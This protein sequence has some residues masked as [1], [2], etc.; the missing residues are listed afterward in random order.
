MKKVFL[1][2]LMSLLAISALAQTDTTIVIPKGAKVWLHWIAPADTDVVAYRIYSHSLY[3]KDS[4]TITSWFQEST[5]KLKSSAVYTMPLP[6]G[7]GYFD[8]IAIDRT[9]LRSALSNKAK[10]EII[11]VAPGAPLIVQLQI[12]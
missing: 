4:L 3:G 9:N 6:V 5:D 2:L 12:M 8:M 1:L 11:E 10:Y 7:P